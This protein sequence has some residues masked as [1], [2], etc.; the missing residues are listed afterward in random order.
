MTIIEI[1]A[2]SKYQSMRCISEEILDKFGPNKAKLIRINPE[3]GITSVYGLHSVEYIEESNFDER[4]RD[5]SVKEIEIMWLQNTALNGISDL[6]RE[7]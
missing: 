2:G 6:Y 1:G 7:L 5:R 4:M 3:R